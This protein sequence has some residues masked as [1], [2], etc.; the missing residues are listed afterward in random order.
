MANNLPE[1]ECIKDFVI[2]EI[3]NKYRQELP[4]FYKLNGAIYL[5][6]CDYIKEQ[7]SFFGKNTYV[8]IMLNERSIDVDTYLY[9]KI[10]EILVKK[11]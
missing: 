10:A 11:I 9:F 4:I 3:M 1:D 8:Y 5:T 2:K 6:Y 7:E